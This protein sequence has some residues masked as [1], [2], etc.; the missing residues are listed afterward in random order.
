MRVLS[1]GLALCLLAVPCARA[2]A[3]ASGDPTAVKETNGENYDKQGN[4][5]FKVAADGT[6]DW[7]SFSGYLRYS[8]NCIVCHGPDG[9]GSTYAPNLTNSFKTIDYGTFIS[10]V[11]QG[12]KNVSASTD[13]VMPAFG[14]NKN[15][16]CY[17]DD[18]YVY[19]RARSNDAVG[20]GRPQ[21][22]EPKPAAWE[23]AQNNCMGP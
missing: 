11:A 2:L 14:N 9:L 6:V 1:I 18:I 10:I 21:K 20:R 4:P 23:T 15:V 19:L 22:H 7:Y 17:I 16:S 5:T 8:S 12:R 3:D 13:F